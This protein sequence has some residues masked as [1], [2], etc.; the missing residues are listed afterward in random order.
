MS[1]RHYHDNAI[2]DEAFAVFHELTR[3]YSGEF[4]IDELRAIVASGDR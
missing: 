4:V 1:S 2:P 3:L